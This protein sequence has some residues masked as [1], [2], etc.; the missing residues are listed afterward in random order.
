MAVICSG[1]APNRGIH[2]RNFQCGAQIKRLSRFFN[3]DLIDAEKAP[4]TQRQIRA[5]KYDRQND[6]RG[7]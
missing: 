4:G 1:P 5:G 6:W 3:H 2:T 7:E